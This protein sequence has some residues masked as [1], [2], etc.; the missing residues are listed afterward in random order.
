M[1][2]L[3]GHRF[4]L[5]LDHREKIPCGGVEYPSWQADLAPGVM[6]Y[7]HYLA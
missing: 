1:R 4:L 2:A 6:F 3:S 5:E 7:P